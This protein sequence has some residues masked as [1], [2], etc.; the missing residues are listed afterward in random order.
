M[1]NNFKR[2]SGAARVSWHT[3]KV[4]A[5]IFRIASL[6]VILN[7]CLILFSDYSVGQDTEIEQPGIL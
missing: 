5:G 3:S 4:L 7:F 6:T 2:R 1:M